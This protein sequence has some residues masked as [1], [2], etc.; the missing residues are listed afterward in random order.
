MSRHDAILSLHQILVTRRDALRKALAGDLSALK[1]FRAQ[2]SGDTVDLAAQEADVSPQLAEVESE[3][4]EYLEE[5]L[6][7]MRDGRFG[8]CEG[9][10]N[11]IPIARLSA[12]LYA[13]Y[14]INC[15]R[16]AERHGPGFTGKSNWSHLLD[17]P[18]TTDK[19]VFL[20]DIEPE[21]LS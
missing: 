20:D 16:Q 10:G 14:C 18:D 3:E 7:K 5:A 2:T 6:E 9:C 1:E 13:K 19:E 21:S 12:V 8:I 15:Q 17:T 11:Q 4:L